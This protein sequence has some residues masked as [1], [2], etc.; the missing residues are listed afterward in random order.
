MVRWMAFSLHLMVMTGLAAHQGEGERMV[1]D[2]QDVTHTLADKLSQS[3]IRLFGSSATPLQVT[4][5]DPAVESDD[6]DE[7][8]EGDWS[9]EGEDDGVVDSDAES[10]SGPLA[11]GSGD[12]GRTTPRNPRSVNRLPTSGAETGNVE[13]AESDSDLGDELG[14]DVGRSADDVSDLEDEDL[15]DEDE[16]EEDG[17]EDAPR[18]KSNLSA[19]ASQSFAQSSRRRKDW[20]K[21]IYSSDQSAQEVV[22]G[23]SWECGCERFGRRAGGRGAVYDQ[24]IRC[25]GRGDF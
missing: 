1:M 5:L 7:D 15:G 14:D 6:E 3:H 19:R 10:E 25:F 18:W 22:F 8:D 16:G 12:R 20:T 2:L 23:K 17:G 24:T 4:G 11:S 21:L 13:Y 9:E